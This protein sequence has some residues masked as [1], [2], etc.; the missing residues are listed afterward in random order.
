MAAVPRVDKKMYFRGAVL[1][2][3]GGEEPPLREA[4]KTLQAIE[5]ET[6]RQNGLKA[7]VSNDSERAES[8]R[9][10]P[11]PLQK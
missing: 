10:V 5:V 1:A 9:T 2:L 7:N 4:A 6:S 8:K 3:N 11:N